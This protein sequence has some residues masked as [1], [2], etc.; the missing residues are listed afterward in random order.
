[1][2]IEAERRSG[3]RQVIVKLDLSLLADLMGDVASLAT[4]VQRRVA[5]AF[6]GDIQ[7]LLVAGEAQVFFRAAGSRLQ[8]LVL[9]VRGMRIVAFEAITPRRRM[10]RTFQVGDV[11][12]SVAGQTERI[13]RGG[14]ELYAC[15]V[16]RYADFMAAC[17][18]GGNGRVDCLALG[19]V[20][21]TL[22]ALG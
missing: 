3:L 20:F 13:G 22:D 21:V 8:Q 9:I 14:D 15:D 7:S 10:D 11:L 17:A 6:V 4:H 1:V 12:V 2:T 18:S 19:L 16:F 5:A